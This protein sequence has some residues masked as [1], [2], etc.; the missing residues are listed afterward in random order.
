MEGSI[1]EN[2]NLRKFTTYFCGFD[3]W[4]VYRDSRTNTD[5]FKIN[6]YK[7]VIS[8]T[9][10]EGRTFERIQNGDVLG[11]EEP[12]ITSDYYAYLSAI[13]QYANPEKVDI[14]IFT[15]PGI[16]YVNNTELVKE[17]VDMIEEER[18]DSIYVVTT[19][20]K[21]RG[22]SDMSSEMF[23]AD[24]A[25]ENLESSDIDSSYSCTYFPWVKFL[26]TTNNVY[27]NLPVTKDVVRNMAETDNVA[28]PWYAPAGFGRGNV[29]CEKAHKS[30][31][32]AEEDIF[33]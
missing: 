13:R 15:T 32:L 31:K 24:E 20:D 19:P 6:T 21:P 27:I 33:I 25:V 3:G 26:D 4:D 11:L 2:V 8:K 10:G 22:A 28:Y 14:N 1:F 18:A 9:N 7:G 16:D 29:E 17:V 23:T 12:A 5:G 30:T